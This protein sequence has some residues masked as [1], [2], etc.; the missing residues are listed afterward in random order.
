MHRVVPDYPRAAR[1][2]GRQG[3]VVLRLHI[4]GDGTVDTVMVAT[5]SGFG[6]LDQAAVAAVGQWRFRP[7]APCWSTVPVT[8]S[9]SS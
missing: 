9:L 4:A 1:R 7:A 3:T 5:S 6:D 8:F 2:A